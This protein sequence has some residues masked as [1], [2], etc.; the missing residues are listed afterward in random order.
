MDD[1]WQLSG[2]QKETLI[3]RELDQLPNFPDS[4]YLSK[5]AEKY[6]ISQLF[7]HYNEIHKASCF[8]DK[9]GLCLA[10][11]FR[12][13]KSKQHGAASGKGPL[14]A[15]HHGGNTCVALV[16]FPLL[17]SHGDLTPSNIYLWAPP[18]STTVGLSFHSPNCINIRLCGLNSPRRFKP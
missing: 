13:W 6:G 14:G 10:H 15:S 11:H 12:S 17:Q 8:I 2:S 18:L 1:W 7:G 16:S 3:N 5:M 9:R 4:I